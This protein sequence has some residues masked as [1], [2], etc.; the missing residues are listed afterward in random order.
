MNAYF[1]LAGHVIETQ[2]VDQGVPNRPPI[3]TARSISRQHNVPQSV[4]KAVDRKAKAD[5]GISPLTVIDSYGRARRARWAL[6]TAA[7]LAA[8][9]GPLPFGDAVAI[10]VLGVYAGYELKTAVGQLL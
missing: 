9:D 3:V 10:G 4:V 2:L 6:T 8:A 1:E 7:S 5:T